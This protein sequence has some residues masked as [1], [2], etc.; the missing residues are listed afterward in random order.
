MRKEHIN[1]AIEN[2]RK[3]LC[4][5][6]NKPNIL[7]DCFKNNVLWSDFIDNRNKLIYRILLYLFKNNIE[8]NAQSLVEILNYET[9]YIHIVE[10]KYIMSIFESKSLIND[11]QLYIDKIKKYSLIKFLENQV[12]DMHRTEYITGLEPIPFRNIDVNFYEN[13]CRIDYIESRIDM[14]ELKKEFINNSKSKKYKIHSILK[15]N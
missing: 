9:M 14:I 4:N 7:I 8:I 3:L 2:E 13:K 6:I 11:T 5:I 1:D 15:Q 12:K 10:Q